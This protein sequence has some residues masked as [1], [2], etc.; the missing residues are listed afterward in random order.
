MSNTPAQNA[1]SIKDFFAREGVQKKFNELLGRRAPGFMTSVLQ[2]VSGNNYLASA[3]PES[4]YTS[5]AMAA[6]LDLP[7]NNSLGFAWIVPYNTSVNVNGQW[8]KKVLAQF[9]IGWKGFVQLAQRTGQYTRINVCEVYENQFVSYNRLTEELNADF[10]KVGE[11]PVVGYVAYFKL[12]NGFE[13]LVYWTAEKVR[14]HA[15]KYSQSYGKADSPWTKHFD[16]MAMKTVLKNTLSKWG[17]LSIEMQQAVVY[18]Q[19]AGEWSD[20][21]DGGEA[22]LYPDGTGTVDDDTVDENAL[23][24]P[25]KFEDLENLVKAGTPVDDLKAQYTNLPADQLQKLNQLEL[26]LGKE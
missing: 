22:V 23:Q 5:A 18:D 2:V 15:E 11:G 19:A 9:Q 17:I 25:P 16:A 13:K 14:E 21:E 7:I 4:V 8:V 1:P 20:T 6:A 10:D 3:T 24:A 12:I 26:D